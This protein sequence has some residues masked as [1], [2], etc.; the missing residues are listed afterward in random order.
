MDNKR[1]PYNNDGVQVLWPFSN[2]AEGDN[3]TNY[4]IDYVSNGFRIRGDNNK[5]NENAK[6]YMYMAFAESPFKYS[7]A[8]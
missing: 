5:V 4:D 3:Y 6:T 2:D 8:R 1:D 7:N